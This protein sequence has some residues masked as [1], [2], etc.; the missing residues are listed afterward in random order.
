MSTVTAKL[1][2]EFEAL[3][4]E[5]KQEFTREFFLRLPPLDS[6]PLHDEV[7]AAAGDEIAAMLDQEENEAR[8]R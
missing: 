3:L 4:P 7:A 1:I 5:E 2:S 8:E 6:G